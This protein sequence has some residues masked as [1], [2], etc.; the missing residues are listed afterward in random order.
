M[1]ETTAAP[2]EGGRGWEGEQISSFTALFRSSPAAGLEPVGSSRPAVNHMCPL[3]PPTRSH[4]AT[5]T[6]P[7]G[8]YKKPRVAVGGRGLPLANIYRGEVKT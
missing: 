6:W 3:L 1:S 7:R 8:S 2:R 4:V 5:D